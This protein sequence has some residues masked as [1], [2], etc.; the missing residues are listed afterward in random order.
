[1]KILFVATVDPAGKSGHNIA[2]RE[3]IEALLEDSEIELSLIY[4]KPS[5][6]VGSVDSY[7]NNAKKLTWLKPKHYGNLCYNIRLQF[8]MIGAFISS[9]RYERPDLIITRLGNS[10]TLPLMVAIYRIPY[11]VL[12][13][14][15]SNRDFEAHL[16]LPGAMLLWHAIMWLNCRVARQVIVA[17]EEIFNE[18]LK[19]R[20]KRQ[21]PPLLFTNAVNPA[22]FPLAGIKE[23]RGSVS[24][25]FKADD[26]IIGFVGSIKKRHGLDILLIAVKELLPL[27]TNLRVMIV[28]EGPELDNLKDMVKSEGL[29]EI[30][31]FSGFVPHEKVSLYNSAADIL[32]GVIDPQEVENPIKCYEYLASAR[33]II[34]SVKQEFDFVSEMQFGVTVSSLEVSEVRHAINYLYKLGPNTRQQIGLRARDYVLTN[35]TWHHLVD[36]IKNDYQN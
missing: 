8:E 12:I 24:L 19:Y 5:N 11:Y 2:T 6:Q 33:P 17:Y 32:Y 27:I 28:G 16:K 14:G 30:V 4:P 31:N 22:L 3:V 34:T 7:T 10:I 20:S 35:H 1:M 21:Q 9:V 18:A 15:L 29:E 25:P 23:A 26:F 13:R 36:L